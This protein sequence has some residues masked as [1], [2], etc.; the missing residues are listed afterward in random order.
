[1]LALLRT[2][3]WQ[4]FTAL[5]IVAIVAFGLLS[6]WQWARA[7]QHRDERAQL[8]WRT[9]QPPVPLAQ[10]LAQPEAPG[11]NEWVPV[12]VTGSWVPGSE[13]LVRQRPL[14]GRNGLWVVGLLREADGTTVAI[15]RGW[16]P[17]TAAATV[18]QPPPRAPTGTVTVQGWLRIAETGP[19]TLP[20][21]LPEGQI[22][23]MTPAVLG[24][25]VPDAYIQAS[26]VTPGEPGLTPLPLPEI[27][28]SRNLSYAVQWILF[29]AV[30]MAGWFF[31]L[32]RE[33]REDEAQAQ[34][35]RSA[36]TVG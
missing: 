18:A 23:S 31:F 24:A 34:A 10:A 9:E 25:S 3:R 20:A 27:D 30:A 29:A 13:H 32:R 2:R 11:A 16:T 33:A 17:A 12:E 8:A 1:M 6:H 21:D 26:V 5:V 28:D 4:A 14:D 15:N 22:P 19:A 35:D 7:E 36:P